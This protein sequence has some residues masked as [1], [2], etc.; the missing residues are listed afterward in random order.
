MSRLTYTTPLLLVA[1][2]LT[3]CP[4][5][6]VPADTEGS[7]SGDTTT[8]DPTTMGPTTTPTTTTVDPDSGS[9]SGESS[10]T[11]EA[12]PCAGVECPPGEECLGGTCFECGQPTCEP[13]CADGETCQC[14]E[15]DLCCDVG[16]CAPPVC[17]LPPLDGNYAD[18]LD[19]MGV[20]SDEPCDGAGCVVDNDG[21]P[22]AAVCVAAGCEATCQCPAAPPTG[23]AT[24]ACEDVTG[25][26]VNDCWLD[27]GGGATCPDDMICF[28][29]FICLWSDV[30]PTEVPLYGDCVNVPGATCAGGFCVQAPTGGV[31][32][33]PCAD[34][35]MD[36]EPGPA[37]GDAV[38]T[39][40]DVTGDMMPECILDCSMGETC[41]DGMECFGGFVCI[42]PEIIPPGD[43]YGDCINPPGTCEPGEDACL[44]D[45]GGMPTAGACSVSGCADA[46]DC[47]AS[48]PTGTSVV[49]CNDFGSGNT[50]YLDC[51][52]GETCPDGMAC[53][54]VGMGMGAGMACLWPVAA[55]YTCADGDLGSAVGAA[56]AMGT[57]LGAGDDFTPSCSG[58]GNDED[59][60][61]QWTAP[62]DGAF[63]FD[64]VGSDF[65]TVLMVLVDCGGS[66]LNCN[67]DTMMLLSEVTVDLLAG[68]SV[69]VV[70]DGWQETGNY[71]L[72]IN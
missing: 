35:M 63:T 52:M 10:G 15:G 20:T 23:D 44:D 7:S 43:S 8:T 11:T 67:D 50:C 24:I 30:A 53:T 4:S 37:T 16:S 58:P 55:D 40:A 25:D 69:L 49:S 70:I 29:G 45:G 21:N 38:I 36:C 22:T 33:A 62:A 60:Q 71:V 14:D 41:A 1:L 17:P 47:P 9:G 13:G 51:S 27:C 66:E 61:F 48:P 56:V 6:D 32:T 42:W 72:N 18:C 39:C 34:A 57:T 46:G 12:D 2:A 64:T 65:D 68:Q 19:D 28:G 31:C 3:A 54:D 26:M 59:V 5:D